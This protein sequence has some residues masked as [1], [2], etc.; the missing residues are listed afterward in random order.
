[1]HVLKEHT[2]TQRTSPVISFRV[3]VDSSNLDNE[4]GQYQGQSRSSSLILATHMATKTLGNSSGPTKD[5]IRPTQ[6]K[7]PIQSLL[8][9]DPKI[10]GISLEGPTPGLSH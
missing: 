5:P 6:L 7:R 9:E 1:M 4:E 3:W 10:G 2:P 8:A